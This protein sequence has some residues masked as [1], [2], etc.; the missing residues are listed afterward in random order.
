[1]NRKEFFEKHISIIRKNKKTCEECGTILLGDYS[2]VAHILEKSK[3]K[4]LEFD[5]TNIIYLCSWKKG[6]DCHYKFDNY[7]NEK[8]AKLKV[9]DKYR[10]V[11]RN[12]LD[13][14]TDNFNYKILDRWLI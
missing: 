14:A 7:S 11:V 10:S 6:N 8:F 12:L 5:D 9:V 3:F 4:S 2:E 13:K 1:M